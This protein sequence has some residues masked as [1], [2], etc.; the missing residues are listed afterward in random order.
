MFLFY[1]LKLL[2]NFME[3]KM[4]CPHNIEYSKTLL[5]IYTIFIKISNLIDYKKKK[6]PITLRSNYLLWLLRTTYD[7]SPVILSSIFA[8]AE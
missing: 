5:T 6:K 8:L 1:R 2:C 7:E 4:F 3:P